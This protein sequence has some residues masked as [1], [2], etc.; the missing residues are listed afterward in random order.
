MITPRRGLDDA[1]GHLGAEGEVAHGQ[2]Y[3]TTD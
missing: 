1:G 2:N 3:D